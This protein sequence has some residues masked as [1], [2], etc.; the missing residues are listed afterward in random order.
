MP[1]AS[2]RPSTV[3]GIKQLAKKI[4]RERTITHTEALELASR[5]AGF[6]NF[7]HARRHLAARAPRFDIYLSA[8]WYN[9]RHAET[10]ADADVRRRGGRELLRIDLSKPLL[11]VVARHRVSAARNLGGFRVEYADHLEHRTN[12][13]SLE[14]ARDTLLAAARTLRFMDATDLQPVTTALQ[15]RAMEIVHGLPEADHSSEWLDP[16]EGGWVLL[17]E[18]YAAALASRANERRAWISDRGLHLQSPDWEGLYYPGECI[19]QLVAKDGG[20]LQRVAAAAIA[21][22]PCPTPAPWPHETG[23]CDD[24][25][26]SPQRIADGRPGKPRPGRSYATHMGATPYGGAP[27][28]R[29]RWRPTKALP[30]ESHL[31][32]GRFL[33]QLARVS[34]S[35]RT[36]SKLT[37]LRSRLDDWAFIEHDHVEAVEKL[38]YG[39]GELPPLDTPEDRQ[40]TLA[41]ARRIVEQ[42]YNDCRP[43]REVLA[44]L[45]AIKAELAPS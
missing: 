13:R 17:D 12:L 18:P 9:P 38:Y 16:V 4:K 41:D 2:I 44:V 35:W 19:P 14:D 26:V 21:L 5:Q 32:L 1:I 43:R 29:S 24:V 3:D 22:G 11:E 10:H 39:A 25:F 40:R 45:D 30:L 34:L 37:Q 42:G 20:L 33:Q 31:Q 7:V 15:L 8:H 36:G 23:L 28:V 6:Q 27:G